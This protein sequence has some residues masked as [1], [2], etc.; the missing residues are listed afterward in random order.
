M[1]KRKLLTSGFHYSIKKQT[2][3][4]KPGKDP[5]HTNL[6]KLTPIGARN[7]FRKNYREFSRDRVTSPLSKPN[8][9][10]MM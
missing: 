7:K 10:D 4:S 5:L 6:P 8:S 9:C 2:P 3:L 1:T